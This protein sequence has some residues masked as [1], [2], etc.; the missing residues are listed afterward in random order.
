MAVKCSFTVAPGHWLY[1][2]K[3]NVVYWH[4]CWRLLEERLTSIDDQSAIFIVE[5]DAL[6]GSG[7]I[8]LIPPHRQSFIIHEPKI[9]ALQTLMWSWEA[10]RNHPKSQRY[11]SRISI[12][13]LYFSE[14]TTIPWS[15]VNARLTSLIESNLGIKNS[16]NQSV[17]F[18]NSYIFK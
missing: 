2:L 6:C 13:Q 16:L 15:L 9:T 5:W 7:C 11:K 14:T 1:T 3:Y 12:Q 17:V 10:Y 18:V 4:W 8:N